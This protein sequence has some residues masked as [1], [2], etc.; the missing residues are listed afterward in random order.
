MEEY[1]GRFSIHEFNV[2]PSGKIQ[3][4]ANDRVKI[5]QTIPSL[6]SFDTDQPQEAA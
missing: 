4:T 6:D 1:R 2:S 5:S 3:M